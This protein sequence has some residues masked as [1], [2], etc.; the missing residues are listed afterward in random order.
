VLTTAGMQEVQCAE[1]VFY[2][3]QQQLE[4]LHRDPQNNR[5]QVGCVQ[6]GDEVPHRFHW[7]KYVDLKVNNLPHRPYGRALNAKMGINQRDDVAS[8]GLMVVRGRNVLSMTAADSGPFIITLHLARRRTLD[9]VKALMAPPEDLDAAVARVRC[10]VGG[11]DGDGGSPAR[12]GPA[13]PRKTMA[14]KLR[15]QAK[16][17]SVR[18]ATGF[19]VQDAA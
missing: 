2:L 6:V 9:Q 1:R 14:C 10:Q 8:I 17:H 19:A 18:H 15:V 4:A 13:A 12:S 5:L 11:G 3:N 7:P 16:M